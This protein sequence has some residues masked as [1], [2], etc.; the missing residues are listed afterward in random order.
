[1]HSIIFIFLCLFNKY[2]YEGWI[3]QAPARYWEIQLR[4]RYS[5]NLKGQLSG[6]EH[7]ASMMIHYS[8]ISI[9]KINSH[10]GQF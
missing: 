4:L 2:L 7:S 1:M 5:L 10:L 6:Q 8:V 3:F 9:V